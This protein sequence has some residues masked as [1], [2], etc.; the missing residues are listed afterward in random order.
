MSNCL[1]LQLKSWVVNQIKID[2]DDKENVIA[3]KK[4]VD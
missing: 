2:R 1:F 3:K 4:Y